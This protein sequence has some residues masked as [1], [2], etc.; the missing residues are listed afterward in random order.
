MTGVAAG[1]DHSDVHSAAPHVLGRE[2]RQ[3]GADAATL[4]VGI[5]ADDVDHAHPLMECV[6][7][8][9][10]ETDGAPVGDCYEDVA[11]AIRAA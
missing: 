4:I 2:P 6:Q 3:A 10:N 5:D 9:G 11:F 1:L 7:S 8:D